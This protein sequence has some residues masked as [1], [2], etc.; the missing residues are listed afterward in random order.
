MR[1]ARFAPSSALLLILSAAT[2]F[3]ALSA[4]QALPGMLGIFPAT[5]KQEKQHI[6]KGGETFLAVWSDTRSALAGNGPI[7]VGGGGP[8]F[9]PGLGTM[10]DIYAARLDASGNVIDKHP[11]VVSPASYNQSHPSVSWNGQNW[12]VV[13]YQE[14]ENDYSKYEIRGVRVSPGGQVLDAAPFKIGTASNN[15]GSWPAELLFDGTTWVVF[16]EGVSASGT[17]RSIFASRIAADGTVLDPAGVAVYEHPTQ[18]LTNPDAAYNGTGYLLV[19]HDLGDQKVYG[20][21][22]TQSLAPAGGR[23]VLNTFEPSMPTHPQVASNGS[24]YLVVWD[25]HPFSGNIGGVA[26]TRVSSSGQVLDPEG[27]AIDE[28]VGVSESFPDVCWNGANWFVTYTSGYYS[29]TKNYTAQTIYVRRVSNT[30]GV[31]DT[32][33][34]RLSNPTTPALFP[35]ITVGFEN[36]V[37][38]LWHDLRDDE[39]IYSA[40]VSAA[41]VPTPERPISLGAPRQSRPRMAFGGD[42]FMTVFQREIAGKAQIFAQRLNST[43]KAIDAEP[44]QVSAG[45][46]QTNVNPSIA[47]NGSNFLVVWSRSETDQHGN[48]IRKVFGRMISPSGAPLNAPFY[49]M[50]GVTP[51]VAALGSTFLTVAIQPI[52]S[53]IRNV[54]CVRVNAEGTVLDAPANVLAGNFNFAPRVAAFANRWLIVWEYHSRHDSSSSW[55]RG[56][57]VEPSGAPQP[58]FQVATNDTTAG[59]STNYDD[60]PHLA[61]AGN[62]ALIVWSDHDFNQNDIKGRRILADGTLLGSNYGFTISNAA[63]SQYFPAVAWDGRQYFVTWLDHRNEQYPEQPR[64]DIYAARVGPKGAVLQQFALA[65]SPAPQET[66]FVASGNGATVFA[67]TAFRAGAPHSALRVV[68]RTSTP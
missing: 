67:Y 12:L 9:G 29:P 58:S 41:G 64:G 40:Q 16:W 38:V 53:Q 61:V 46:N 51:D 62:S 6:A 35:A 44:M 5:G 4:P 63:G 3:A 8:Y 15:H 31:I 27:L 48:I 34:I 47:F 50:D 49:V 1:F 20:V 52:G 22:L 33:P 21:R 45:P 66:P 37:Q 14:L 7:S 60:T 65:N 68:T 11:I 10:N 32:A 54:A 18:F 43:G 13:W 25:E 19:F 55:I 30:G 39:D 42:V 2:S 59:A 26:G 36:A 23:F 56:S 24:G 57:F 17:T 28:N